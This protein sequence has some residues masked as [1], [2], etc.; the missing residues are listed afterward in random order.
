MSGCWAQGTKCMEWESAI[1]VQW[2]LSYKIS[3]C[4]YWNC[5]SFA[6]CNHVMVLHTTKTL[7]SKFGFEY[8]APWDQS[9]P[10]PRRLDQSLQSHWDKSSLETS[11]IGLIGTGHKFGT[12]PRLIGTSPNGP[13]MP[14]DRSFRSQDALG[15]IPTTPM[16]PRDWS[17]MGHPHI[18]PP[19]PTGTWPGQQYPVPQRWHS[20]S[21]EVADHKPWLECTVW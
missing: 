4:T 19:L 7:S 5:L 16:A 1:Q 8:H 11:P 12:V 13:K 2:F 20:A 9:Q 6:V 21:V 14:W 15:H 17:Q 10:V 3:H 18:H